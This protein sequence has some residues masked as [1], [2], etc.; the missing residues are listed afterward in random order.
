MNPAAAPVPPATEGHT[1]AEAIRAAK[2]AA[3]G[4]ALGLILLVLARRAAR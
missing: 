1:R 2:A 4:T 3:L